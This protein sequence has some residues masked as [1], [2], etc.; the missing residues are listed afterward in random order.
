MSKIETV[1]ENWTEITDKLLRDKQ[2]LAHFLRFS[3]S[4]YKQ[5]FSDEALRIQQKLCAT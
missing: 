3:A 5:S 2:L 4:M 1:R